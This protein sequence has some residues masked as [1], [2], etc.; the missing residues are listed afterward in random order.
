MERAVS[1]KVSILGD[2]AL[3]FLLA[4]ASQVSYMQARDGPQ[5]GRGMLSLEIVLLVGA[6]GTGILIVAF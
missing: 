6:S 1:L 3:V 5:T 4:V 2:S